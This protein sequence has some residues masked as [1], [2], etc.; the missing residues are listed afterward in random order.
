LRHPELV[1]GSKYYRLL[2][3]YQLEEST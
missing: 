2:E 3:N 1:E